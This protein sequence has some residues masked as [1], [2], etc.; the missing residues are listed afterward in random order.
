MNPNEKKPFVLTS[1]STSSKS[2]VCLPKMVSV[3]EACCAWLEL[4]DPTADL[5]LAQALTHCKYLMVCVLLSC[6]QGHGNT[7]LI[8]NVPE[9]HGRWK[10]WILP[11]YFYLT[12]TSLR[13]QFSLGYWLDTDWICK[14]LKCIARPFFRDK[15]ARSFFS[16][17]TK[18]F[19]IFFQDNHATYWN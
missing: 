4:H 2:P 13:S 10:T 15:L 9:W 7:G 1:Q 8:P 12:V 5:R 19:L 6:A 16:L 11:L 18:I 14:I 17:R 3:T